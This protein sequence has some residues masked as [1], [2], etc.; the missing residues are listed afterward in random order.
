MTDPKYGHHHQKVRATLLPFAY[1]KPCI[2]CG[3]IMLPGEALALDHSVDGSFYRGIVHSTC[4]SREG[5][6]RGAAR[7]KQQSIIFPGRR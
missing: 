1:G 5:G 7:K 6:R 3:R 2:H 4:N